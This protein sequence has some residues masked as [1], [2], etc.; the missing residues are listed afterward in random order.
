ME[1]GEAVGSQRL[2]EMLLRQP[3]GNWVPFEP[4][5]MSERRC[6]SIQKAH[7]RNDDGFV[8]KDS[9]GDWH[10]PSEVCVP[11]ASLYQAEPRPDELTRIRQRLK[12][13]K[14][15]YNILIWT[16]PNL[17]YTSIRSRFSPI[18]HRSGVCENC[19]AITRLFADLIQRPFL[20]NA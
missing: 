11:N 13:K 20:M 18:A 14:Q 8:L 17:I 5:G 12:R 19:K 2:A 7:R 16:E 10:C 15:L 4:Q 9:R 6:D 3:S 1:A